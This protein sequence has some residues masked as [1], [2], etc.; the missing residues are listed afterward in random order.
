MMARISL[1]GVVLGLLACGCGSGSNDDRAANPPGPRDGGKKV[2]TRPPVSNVDEN[3]DADPREDQ[4]ADLP[5]DAFSQEDP[6]FIAVD[7]PKPIELPPAGEERPIDRATEEVI[8]DSDAK[9]HLAKMLEFMK[10]KSP[11]VRYEA[12]LVVTS[13]ARN[14]RASS[15]NASRP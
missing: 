9:D 2:A 6:Q 13:S 1:C 14:A 3:R 4:T 11:R 5:I 7:W 8:G 15:C 12:K 10:H